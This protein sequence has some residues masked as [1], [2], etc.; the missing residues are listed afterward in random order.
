MY[1]M[2]VA[3]SGCPARP[4]LVSALVPESEALELR[5]LFPG[6]GKPFY[7]WA[8][9]AV[10]TLATFLSGP[11]QSFVFSIFVDPII[12]D[13]GLSR[14]HVSTL[15]AL[16][17]AVS[18]A[19]VVVVARMVDRFGARLMLAGIA[20]GLG[21]ACFGMSFA[22]GPVALFFGFAALRA[23]G[24]G[25]LPTTA[26]ILTAQWFVK[27]RGRA[28]SVVILGLALSNAALPAL[29]QFLVGSVG[30]RQ[31]YMGL[32]L[33]V[34]VLL[35]PA[36]LFI[37]RDRP[38]AIGAHPDGAE[39]S[40]AGEAEDSGPQSG[41]DRKRVL[42]SPDFWLL[43]LPIAA[44]PFVVTALVFHQISILGGNGISAAAAA[45]IFVA[46]AVA[47]A[48]ATAL[49][50]PLIERLGPRWPL[51]LSLGLLLAAVVGL[52]FVT[53]PALATVYAL[54]LGAAS[55]VH[56]VVNGVIWA[57]YYG[58]RGLGA[59]QGPATMVS[60]SAAALAPLPLAALQQ[61]SGS[62]ALGLGV[63]AVIPVACALL[64]TLFDP[65]RAKRH[66]EA[67]NA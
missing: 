35:I 34:W 12:A 7:G 46:F 21:V 22:A 26:S 6:S 17:T 47:S 61:L 39:H 19:M 56:G 38:E 44:I 5:S 11:G 28:M 54:V 63:M 18:A 37:V 20:L 51:W 9:V 40:P 25:S 67:V 41:G 50:G 55:G 13:T 66:V 62:Y 14:V 8:V 10:A 24:Q 58:R 16:G 33:M 29:S 15:Y 36:A 4:G 52:Q 53:T 49:A 32:G 31:A 30:W 57:H 60:I 64:A 45:G 48:G 65:D 23:L 3:C 42:L 27:H 43:A 2:A 59:V 1:A